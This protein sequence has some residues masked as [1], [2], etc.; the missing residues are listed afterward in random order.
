MNLAC[1]H[2]A[3]E[4]INSKTEDIVARVKEITGM[5]GIQQFLVLVF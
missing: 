4:V 2:R 1:M 3:D 5:H